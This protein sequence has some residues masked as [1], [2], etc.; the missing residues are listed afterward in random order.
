MS[1]G[2]E[3]FQ[4]A[5]LHMLQRLENAS[6]GSRK[7]DDLVLR[8]PIPMSLP[9]LG[10]KDDREKSG[11]KTNQLEAAAVTDKHTDPFSEASINMISMA[12]AEK[13]K[14]KVTREE[15]R[16]LVDQPI[17][18]GVNLPEYPKATIFK[19]RVL[20]SKCQ[21]E[22]ELEIPP[23]GAL[24]D[25][26]LIRRNEEQKIKE[27]QEKARRTA[28]KDTSR[29]VFQRLGGDSQ[30]RALSEIFRNHEVSEEAEDKDAKKP[31]ERS[32]GHSQYGH[33]GREVRRTDR[34]TNPVTKDNSARL[35]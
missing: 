21:C 25:H 9:Y 32:V 29:S 20:C 10:E 16:R 6:A 8:P 15:E 17:K 34:I 2:S 24:I 12:W 31:K 30:P 13:G 27:A 1:K 33:M 23:A 22:C 7:E 11:H 14:E 26:E 18:W 35:G 4:T 19:G 3:D 28:G 5:L